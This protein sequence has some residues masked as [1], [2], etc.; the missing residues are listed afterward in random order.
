[1]G[2]ATAWASPYKDGL[3]ALV[4]IRREFDTQLI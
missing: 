1:M 4:P 3:R 2:F